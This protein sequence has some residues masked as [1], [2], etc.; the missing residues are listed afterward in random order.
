MRITM[1]A[2]VFAFAFTAQAQNPYQMNPMIQKMQSMSPA[3]RDA[4]AKNMQQNAQKMQNCYND[5]GGQQ[6]MGK[7]AAQGK[8]V[9]AEIKKLCAAG[10]RDEALALAMKE[11]KRMS[12]D[13]TVKKMQACSKQMQANTDFAFMHAEKA[14]K[15]H[16]CD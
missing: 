9:S 3:E 5:A 1:A 7:M 2:F 13:P 10:K 14:G 8:Q 6:A 12:N 15:K 16:I 11:G 4:W